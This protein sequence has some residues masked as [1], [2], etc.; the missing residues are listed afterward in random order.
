MNPKKGKK[1][2]VIRAENNE[3]ES[4]IKIVPT[5]VKATSF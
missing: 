1:T 3:I 5:K 4:D 2:V